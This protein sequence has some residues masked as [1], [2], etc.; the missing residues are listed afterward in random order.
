MIPEL[1]VQNMNF[2]HPILEDFKYYKTINPFDYQHS[3]F[4]PNKIP[5]LKSDFFPINNLLQTN[6]ITFHKIKENISHLNFQSLL[7]E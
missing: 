4:D 2:F 5:L 3:S 1:S 6:V 7:R